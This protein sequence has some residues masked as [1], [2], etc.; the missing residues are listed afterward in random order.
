[1]KKGLLKRAGCLGMAL[2][3]SLGGLT[4]C[5][6][7]GG[8]ENADMAKE[9]VYRFQ[10][11]EFPDL[12]D[13]SY[14][15]GAYYVDGKV[16]VVMQ[17]YHWEDNSNNTD[18]QLISMNDDGSD[19]QMVE[20]EVPK[21]ELTPEELAGEAVPE[22]GGD[23][24]Q[25]AV[26][27]P[28][29]EE[30]IVEEEE[31]KDETSE[32]AD[33]EEGSGEDGTEDNA[34]EDGTEADG[35]ADVTAGLDMP[36]EEPMSSDIYE[37]TNLGNFAFSSNGVS[38]FKTYYYN[39]YTNGASVNRTSVCCWNMDGS[40]KWET[41]LEDLETEDAYYYVTSMTAA[42][43]G[44]LTMFFSGTNVL[45]QTVSPDGELGEREAL[46]DELMT[47]FNHAQY[48]L[49]RNDGKLLLVY[50]SEDDWQDQYMVDYDP[51]TDQLS[52]P[53][54][55]P[56]TVL[57]SS[58]GMMAGTVSDVIYYTSSGICVYNRGDEAGTEI[59]NFINSDVGVG[60]FRNVVQLDD[61]RFI[62]FFNE[63][64]DYS[65]VKAGLFTYVPP[66]EI[67][68]KKVIVLACVYPDFYLKKRIVE[69]N[70]SS[71]EYK[72][73]IKSYDQ[74]NTYDDYEAGVTQLNND[75]ISGNM[76]DILVA[77]ELP[78]SNYI[79]KGL[80]ADI[81]KMIQEDEELSQEEFLQNVFDACSVDGKLYYVIPSF[82]VRTVIAK[83]SLVGDRTGWT[84][85]DMLALGESMPD[86]KLFSD[87]PR[88]QF[89]QLVMNYCGTEFVNPDTGLCSFNS[90]EFISFMEY[91]KTLPEEIVYDEDYW[92]NFN[93]ESQYREDKSLLFTGV[94]SSIADMNYT[95]NGY[96]GEDVTFVGFPTKEGNGSNIYMNESYCIS[97]K[98]KN[99][100]GA[101]EFLRYYL[102]E[103]YQKDAEEMYGLPVLKSAFEEKAKEA[104]ERPYYIDE[105]GEKV[106]YDETFYLNGE[107]IPLPPMSQEQIDQVVDFVY[108]V[109]RGYYYNT[110]V[111][112][113][114]TEEMGSFYA[115]QK[116][117]QEV[118]DVIQRRVQI[119]VDENS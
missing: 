50:Y 98:S 23:A 66:E 5:G 40:L 63:I 83:K 7:G 42:S 10:E 55:L 9:H 28:R 6:G 92:A 113:I 34:E 56:G 29:M 47:V 57:Y 74:Y 36:V 32:T 102:T 103:A 108:S 93:Y 73:V 20:L 105:N 69:F 116:S 111:M 30:G 60:S 107:S 18:Y 99:K 41:P 82:Y 16:Y 76:P 91:A 78:V 110:D 118:A 95:I 45:R 38:G 58:M 13:D 15:Q 67:P 54:E 112:N 90:P 80:V 72:I 31:E 94:I 89:M 97:A 51:A 65:H 61:K 109:D 46:P 117:A 88:E 59:M 49:P 53:V 85:D 62:G 48:T 11:L 106:E 44:T 70:R 77:D 52:E 1:M 84:M 17:V 26:P 75:I 27:I 4:A 68:D 114:I 33:G 64:N 115:D 3:L 39:N 24:G 35:D 25:E 37:S 8:M 22:E 43:D 81:G 12:G 101:W 119:Y 71:E 86:S 2:L 100:D 21:V 79:S 19:L 104:L 96:F 87:I 14:M